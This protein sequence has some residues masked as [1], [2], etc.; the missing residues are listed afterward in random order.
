[1]EQ[2]ILP[3]PQDPSGNL[4]H[5]LLSASE[6]NLD[7]AKPQRICLQNLSEQR[8]TQSKLLFALT[9][10]TLMLAAVILVWLRRYVGSW[11]SLV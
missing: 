10:S 3:A 9:F 4:Q 5:S 8:L 6:P 1:M 11:I 2:T 7:A